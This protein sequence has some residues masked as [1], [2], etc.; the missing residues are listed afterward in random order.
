MSKILVV[1]DDQAVSEDV[2]DWLKHEQHTVEAV[3][4]GK[5]GFERLRLYHYDVAIIDWELPGMSGI[6]ICKSYRACGGSAR[7]LMLTGKEAAEEI[8]AGL[9]AGADDYL[10]KP[11]HLK[12]LSARLRALVRRPSTVEGKVLVVGNL[13][14]ESNTRKVFASGKELQLLPKELALLEFLLKHSNQTYNVESLLNHI[15]SSESDSSVSTVYTNM[16]TL[17][18]TLSAADCADVIQTVHRLGYRIEIS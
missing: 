12:V 5:E 14:Y 10:T 2:T 16:H 15:W 8:E 11:F 1:E 4:D 3:L 9:D 13:S 17:K 7:I 6:E 18:K